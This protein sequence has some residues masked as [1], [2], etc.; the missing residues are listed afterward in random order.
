MSATDVAPSGRLRVPGRR[1]KRAVVL[2]YLL[3]L[4]SLFAAVPAAAP[5]VAQ[6]LPPADPSSI[7]TLQDENAS[8]SASTPT[9]R[10]YVNGLRLGYTSPTGATPDFLQRFGTQIFGQGRQRF[11]IDLMQQMFTPED[12]GAAVPPPYDRPYAG[13]LLATARLIQD[14]LVTRNVL[15][16][17]VGVL[18]PESGAEGLQDG[19]HDLIG[20]G[21]DAGWGSQL[22]SAPLGEITLDHTWR[23]PLGDAGGLAFDALPDVTLAAGNLRS[24]AMAGAVFRMGQGLD[25]DF[26]VPRLQPGLSGGD[27]YTPTRPFVWYVFAG[28]DGQLVGNDITFDTAYAPY[29]SRV[30]LLHEVGEFEA[31]IAFIWHGVRISYT[32]VFQSHEFATQQGGLHEFGSLAASFRF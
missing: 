12:T 8:I 26:G 28:G 32:Q 13:V 17:S 24:Y 11:E 18:G 3:Y 5:A 1:A 14:T 2:Q 7:L 19:F 16:L 6:T 25:S 31:G 21:H 20:Q 15:S 9:D 29:E 22:R 23:L 30:S 4:A 10:L 27:A